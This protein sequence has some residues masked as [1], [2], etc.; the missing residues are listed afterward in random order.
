MTVALKEIKGAACRLRET[1]FFNI[2]GAGVLNKIVSFASG[3]ILI[4]VLSRGDYGAYS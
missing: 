3:V 1:G 4:R 2:V